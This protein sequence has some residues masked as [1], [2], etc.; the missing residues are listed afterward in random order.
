MTDPKNSA[1]VIAGHGSTQNPDI[2][3]ADPSPCGRRS[4]AAGV[5]RGGLLPS[6]KEEPYY[7][8]VRGHGE[9]SGGFRGAELHQRGVFT[10]TVIPPGTW[11][12]TARSHA[13]EA[14]RSATANPLETTPGRP[15][16]P[17]AEA[18]AVAP[19]ARPCETSLVIVGHGTGRR[20]QLGGGREEAGP[21][22]RRN[23]NITA[24]V[25]SAYMEGVPLI[26][27]VAHIHHTAER[28]RRPV[29]HLH[30]RGLH[31]YQ[32]TPSVLG[33]AQETPAGRP[34]SR[35]MFSNTIPTG[36]AA[37]G[38]TTEAAPCRHR[39][40]ALRGRHRPRSGRRVC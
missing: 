30:N 1:L 4:V 24:E 16:F 27:G 23:W 28:R 6:W 25:L 5:F 22:D 26:S 13:G 35:R 37:A 17:T 8:D 40:R 34:A 9:I 2:Q 12:W 31:S 11:R 18:R 10:K 36:S 15:A 32:D 33:I 19:D 38:F 3:R 29:L 39:S 20:R 21:P 7:R 14:A